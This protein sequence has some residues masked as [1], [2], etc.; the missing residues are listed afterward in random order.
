MQEAIAYIHEHEQQLRDEH[1]PS[2]ER[3]ALTDAA[4]DILVQSGGV[5]LLQA[6]SHGGIEAHPA[7]FFE[8]VR[9][10]GRYNPS[11]GWIAGVVGVHHAVA[12][13]LR[14]GQRNGDAGD[15]EP[16]VVSDDASDLAGQ[17]RRDR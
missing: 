17:V 14:G 11:A 2:D 6:K 3:G 7:E 1:V 10:A 4:R 13:H 5:R 12:Q 15:R 8:W 16:A 9:A